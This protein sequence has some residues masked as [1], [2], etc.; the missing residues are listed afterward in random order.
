VH[1]CI[2]ASDQCAY[3]LPWQSLELGCA[4]W[5]RQLVAER[6]YWSYVMRKWVLYAPVMQRWRYE[7]D[8]LQWVISTLHD[9][10]ATFCIDAILS[11]IPFKEH[12][13]VYGRN[14]RLIYDGEYIEVLSAEDLAFV[15]NW[16]WTST[17]ELLILV[18]YTM[19][20]KLGQLSLV[21]FSSRMLEPQWSNGTKSELKFDMFVSP[22]NLLKVTLCWWWLGGQ[23]RMVWRLA[24]SY[25]DLPVSR[26]LLQS[27]L[28]SEA[29]SCQGDRSW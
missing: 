29:Q 23:Y 2:D 4:L 19:F 3:I 20:L 8:H 14:E 18:L 9:C 21:F 13:C 27:D 6:Y 28:I 17:K 5:C 1:R 12:S 24:N 10:C 7:S 15:L 25:A 11:R 16:H 26:K 22:Q